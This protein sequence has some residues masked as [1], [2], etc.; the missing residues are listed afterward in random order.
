MPSSV[1]RVLPTRDARRCRPDLS[2]QGHRADHSASPRARLADGTTTRRF[3][4]LHTTIGRLATT[5]DSESDGVDPFLPYVDQSF[6]S[7][8]IASAIDRYSYL[9][10]MPLFELTCNLAAIASFSPLL[11]VFRVRPLNLLARCL[12]P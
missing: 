4:P 8:A 2:L 5:M 6:K 3:T 10:M 9:C 11:A 1:L 7:P 12:K